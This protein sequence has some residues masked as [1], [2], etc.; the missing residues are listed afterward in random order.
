MR[1]HDLLDDLQLFDASVDTSVEVRGDDGVTVRAV[2]H[3]S[4]HVVE[5]ALF[6]CIR[7][8]HT[9]GHDHA[10]AAVAAATVDACCEK[11]GAPHPA[12]PDHSS[13]AASG[14]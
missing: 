8:A 14:W 10:V 5:G 9:D 12:S 6:C 1:L 3:D 7:G 2:V 11:Y 4:R 13:T